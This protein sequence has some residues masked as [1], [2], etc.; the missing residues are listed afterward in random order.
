[1]VYGVHHFAAELD[2]AGPAAQVPPV[3]QR[4]GADP[5]VVAGR[6]LVRREELRPLLGRLPL[7]QNTS[8]VSSSSAL[9]AGAGAGLGVGA[10]VGAAVSF[11]GLLSFCA[12][13]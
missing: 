1:L 9:G 3:R 10:G 8:P 7:G 11:T 13:L 6:N 4:A 12:G 5:P 2:V